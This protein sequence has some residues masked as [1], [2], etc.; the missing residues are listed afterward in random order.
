MSD[1]GGLTAADALP[2]HTARIPRAQ[3]NNIGQTIKLSFIK[4][5][6]LKVNNISGIT[7]QMATLRMKIDFLR[8]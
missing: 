7:F 1:D 6:R 3:Y 8:R 2:R 4:R 5:Q